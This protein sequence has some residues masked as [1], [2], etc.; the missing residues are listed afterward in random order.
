MA[1]TEDHGSELPERPAFL[2]ERKLWKIH[3]FKFVDES[4]VKSLITYDASANRTLTD[5]IA[6]ADVSG[7]LL[8]DGRHAAIL[9]LDF[10][11][12]YV[13]STESNHAHLYLNLPISKFRWFVLM[14]ALRYAKVVEQGF[15]MWSLRRGQNFARLPWVKKSSEEKGHYSY[16][17]FFRLRPRK[18]S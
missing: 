11:H 9:D 17:W 1:S 2:G 4:I 7:S 15:F 6:E 16:G 10:D 5:N 14:C 8:D 3:D 13:P 18:D 12:T